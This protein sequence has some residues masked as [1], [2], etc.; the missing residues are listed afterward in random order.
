MPIQIDYDGRKLLPVNV[1]TDLHLLRFLHPDMAIDSDGT[2]VFATEGSPYRGSELTL[3][4][5]KAGLNL[6]SKNGVIQYLTDLG[7]NRGIFWGQLNRREWEDIP[8]LF[9]ALSIGRVLGYLPKIQ[10]TELEAT[11]DLLL[12]PRV[13][14]ISVAL[15]WEPERIVRGVFKVI[16]TFSDRSAF[17][18]YKSVTYKKKLLQLSSSFVP[19]QKEFASFELDTEFLQDSAIQ[20][21]LFFA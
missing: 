10:E 18:N 3:L 15:T 8:E 14:R 19:Y 11:A 6:Y 17:G 20:L 1:Y 13:E 9:K 12:L 5:S 7:L 4:Q 2:V 21:V 16:S